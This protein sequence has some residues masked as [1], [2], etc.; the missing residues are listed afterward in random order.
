MYYFSFNKNVFMYII[1]FSSEKLPSKSM[2]MDNNTF[3]G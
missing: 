1:V 3:W 2:Y